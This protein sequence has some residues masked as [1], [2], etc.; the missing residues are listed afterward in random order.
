MVY[1]WDA[2]YFKRDSLIIEQGNPKQSITAK[3]RIDLTGLARVP[4]LQ[5]SFDK[6]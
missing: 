1:G 4:N 3:V 5:A 6:Y 2:I